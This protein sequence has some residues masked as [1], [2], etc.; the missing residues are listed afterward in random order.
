MFAAPRAKKTKNSTPPSCTTDRPKTFLLW[1]YQEKKK[2]TSQAF[3]SRLH[4]NHIYTVTHISSGS[5]EDVVSTGRSDKERLIPNRGMASDTWGKVSA[6]R[7]RN[8][9]NESKMVTPA[10]E[11]SLNTAS[12]RGPKLEIFL[13]S[14]TGRRS[15]DFLPHLPLLRRAKITIGVFVRTVTGN[16]QDWSRCSEWGDSVPLVLNYTTR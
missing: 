15:K 14:S 5:T 16:V 13:S 10:T 4:N 3:P 9:V 11:H 1:S 7:F 6:T 2:T 12:D 8:T